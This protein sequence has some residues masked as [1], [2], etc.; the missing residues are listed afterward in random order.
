MKVTIEISKREM[1]A[2]LDA[3]GLVAAAAECSEGKELKSAKATGF[4]ISRVFKRYCK[5][6]KKLKGK[7]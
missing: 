2:I 5:A 3:D 1:D 7:K 4:H 6:V